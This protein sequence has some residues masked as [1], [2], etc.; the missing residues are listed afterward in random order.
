LNPKIPC[1]DSELL[2]R[3]L[4]RAV[5]SAS[6]SPRPPACWCI[7]RTPMALSRT[8][9]RALSF[10]G[11]VQSA[12]EL[13]LPPDSLESAAT[14]RPGRPGWLAGPRKDF[15]W[16]RDSEPSLAV[17]AP[18]ARVQ[19]AP[20]HG[21]A[22]TGTAA[23][24]VLPAGGR[25]R[26]GAR[27]LHCYLGDGEVVLPPRTSLL[28]AGASQTIKLHNVLTA[29]PHWRPGHSPQE[30]CGVHAVVSAVPCLRTGER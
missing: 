30:P 22:C 26:L 3:R 12:G 17:S 7:A 23:G 19:E 24:R 1:S 16:A 15:P 14:H 6:H 9:A 5:I 21:P 11:L 20:N 25:P 2:L 27:S 4:Q 8:P 18:E 29:R 10:L 13:F 28:R